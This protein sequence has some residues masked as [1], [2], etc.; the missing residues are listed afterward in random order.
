[1]PRLLFYQARYQSF[2]RGNHHEK[3][4]EILCLSFHQ[5]S[6]IR[7]QW[8]GNYFNS[9]N[10][11]ANR[12]PRDLS[13]PGT[14]ANGEARDESLPLEEI[15]TDLQKQFLNDPNMSLTD[16]ADGK[17]EKSFPRA[18]TLK[19]GEDE[20]T[21]FVELATTADFTNSKIYE[22]TSSLPLENL[23]LA[24]HYY[25]RIAESKADLAT[26]EVKGFQSSFMAPRNV[27]VDG[28]TNFRDIGGWVTIDKKR[29]KQ[30]L[31][32]RCGRFNES[33]VKVVNKEITAAGEKTLLQDLGMKT[34]VD[35]RYKR[36]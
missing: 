36:L 12:D 4:H 1:M 2:K 22:T 26:S 24:T 17:E 11:V 10:H 33:G 31:I 18:N 29:T 21:R 32:Y 34:E 9:R 25:Y 15:H 23:L 28:V 13:S 14:V 35:L 19:V 30:G 8:N 27:Q 20:K 6:A 7:L 16:V 3:I 5:R